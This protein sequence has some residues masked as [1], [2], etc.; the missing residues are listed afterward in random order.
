MPA[1][2]RA[3]SIGRYTPVVGEPGDITE[4]FT[5][6]AMTPSM[7]RLSTGFP[8]S[9]TI[10]V[11]HT[12]ANVEGLDDEDDGYYEA[13]ELMYNSRGRKKRMGEKDGPVAPSRGGAGAGAA[14]RSVDGTRYRRGSVQSRKWSLRAGILT[15][16][17]AGGAVG[18]LAYFVILRPA[19]TDISVASSDLSWW[20]QFDLDDYVP[21]WL[22]GSNPGNDTAYS[23]ADLYYD[24]AQ[25]AQRESS[26][27]KALDAIIDRPTASV[28]LGR[29]TQATTTAVAS[30]KDAS[31]FRVAEDAVTEAEDEDDLPDDAASSSSESASFNVA[32]TG[33]FAESVGQEVMQMADNGTLST[34]KWHTMLP[35]LAMA[36]PAKA[37]A[38]RLIIVGECGRKIL[39]ACDEVQL[40]T[41]PHA[42]RRCSRHASVPCLATAPRVVLDFARHA[43]P[44]GRHPDQIVSRRFAANDRFTAAIRSSWRSRQQ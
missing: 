3:S 16:L 23:T 26:W 35:A 5:S 19:K 28:T 25:A 20:Q 11:G 12:T 24:G 14:W 36:S 44:H 42:L 4:S 2:R 6:S 37:D 30:E 34:Y 15:L 41:T 7:R 40:L 33:R 38:G 10:N 17:L 9:T 29:L 1:H 22:H 18:G 13:D 27:S 39:L 32:G 43:H 8:G 31:T 21:T